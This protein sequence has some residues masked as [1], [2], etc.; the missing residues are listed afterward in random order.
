MSPTEPEPG[1]EAASRTPVTPDNLGR[2]KLA[3]KRGVQPNVIMLSESGMKYSALLAAGGSAELGRLV[4]VV[5]DL[6]LARNAARIVEIIQKAGKSLLR[7]DAAFLLLRNAAHWYYADDANVAAPGAQ[8][9][10]SAGSFLAGLVMASGEKLSVAD[11]GA[12]ARIPAALTSALRMKSALVVPIRPSDPV[13]AIGVYWA[14]RHLPGD[15]ELRLLQALAEAAACACEAVD[16]YAL[17]E[18]RIGEHTAELEREIAERREAQHRLEFALSAGR[19]AVWDFDVRSG[20]MR[21]NK[22]LPHLLGRGEDK[23]E[24]PAQWLRLVHREDRAAVLAG[25]RRLLE[26]Q[27]AEYRAEFRVRAGRGAWRWTL[28]QVKVAESEADGRARRLIGIQTDIDENR[29]AQQEVRDALADAETARRVL[30]ALMDH[31]PLGILIADTDGSIRAASR[32]GLRMLQYGEGLPPEKVAELFREG[33]VIY[34]ADGATPVDI[35]AQP[36]MRAM[37]SGETIDEEEMVI[38][39]PD[40]TRVPIL[41]T[42]GPIRDER[43]R[44]TGGVMAWQDI[45]RR[46]RDEFALRESE[47]R[48]RATFEQ[49]A[50]GVAHLSPAGYWLRVNSKLR[51]MLGYSSDELRYRTSLDITH[52]DDKQEEETALRRLIEG[53]I[54]SLT[55]EKRYLNHDGTPLWVRVT[56]SC[57]RDDEGAPK[58]VI[59][60]IED[61]SETRKLQETLRLSAQ[62]DPLT[63]LANRALIH[64]FGTRLLAGARRGGS[65]AAL[66]FIDLDRFKPINDTYGHEAGDGVLREVARRLRECVRSEDVLGRLGGDEFVAMISHMHSEADAMK[67]ASHVLRT[68]GQP[69]AVRDLTLEVSP[70]IG[71]SLF[72]QDG[73]S[74]D[75]LLKNADTAMYHAKNTGR[76]R[77]Q[78]FRPDLNRSAQ[79]S[80]HLESRLRHA[81]EKDEFVLHYQ[82]IHDTQTGEVVAAEAL[83]R[84]PAMK[85]EPER[86]L[87]LLDSSG[88]GPALSR[89]VVREACRQRREWRGKGLR[90]GPISINVSAAQFA[91]DGFAE[92][93]R[94]AMGLV[95]VGEHPICLE[96]PEAA[97][98]RDVEQS[99]R[100]LQSL[101]DEGIPIALA[102]C[103]S[104]TSLGRL[105]LDILKLHPAVVR[106][107]DRDP[108]S[109]AIADAMI[110]LGRSLGMDVVAEGVESAEVA[111]FLR[112]RRCRKSQGF[113]F[114]R[115][116]PGADFEQACVKLSA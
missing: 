70:S 13:G 65:G 25:L 8:E 76:N 116:M 73:Y 104:W 101:H 95:E 7:A 24:S 78:F 32:C 82:P 110:T 72:P 44:I 87:P 60:V 17:L 100:I 66:L 4:D 6:S 27:Q 59:A 41:S 19:M 29:R 15:D 85:A 36:L 106:T 11:L 80:L 49:A 2:R 67:A 91:Q 31:I 42:A 23:L 9:G 53:D 30:D 33:V 112:A 61:I 18:T 109:A 47:E 5:Q 56:Q 74:V 26:G 77:L 105:P 37:T 38:G 99:A 16:A 20:R 114:S 107:I 35:G 22:G 79:E 28:S 10:R 97:V 90:L 69:Y 108:A 43:G 103:S 81:L 64:E 96:I 63:G 58:Y 57:V 111:S 14:Q 34:E 86:F 40:G 89:W 46:K 94:E 45:T 21:H 84:W 54:A 3:E 88:C 39:L 92:S 48:F 83:L 75:D 98:S 102:K 71:V 68:L 51:R 113:Y 115:P 1:D 50:V 93:V 55:I 12:D 52:P 62:H